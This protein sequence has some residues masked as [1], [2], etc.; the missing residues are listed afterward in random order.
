M[1]FCIFLCEYEFT[2]VTI[3]YICKVLSMS[4]KSIV[5]GAQMFCTDNDF[6]ILTSVVVWLKAEARI[7][8]ASCSDFVSGST[9]ST[10]TRTQSTV[11]G[12]SLM[13]VW[14]FHLSPCP[15]NVS[16]RPWYVTYACA[17]ILKV[18]NYDMSSKSLYSTCL[19]WNGLPIIIIINKYPNDVKG[20]Q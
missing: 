9:C 12:C 8:A 3:F 16:A 19:F 2:S 4:T 14:V 13:C 10:L 5:K 20:L 17:S 18:G 11:T 1:Y 7:S 6:S 15:Q